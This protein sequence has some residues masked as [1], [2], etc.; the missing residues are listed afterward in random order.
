[1]FWTLHLASETLS[2]LKRVT[3]LG[4]NDARERMAEIEARKAMGRP[5]E[6]APGIPTDGW[7]P[8]SATEVPGAEGAVG[9]QGTP[10]RAA[11][12]NFHGHGRIGMSAGQGV[13]RR[14][15]WS[16]RAIPAPSVSL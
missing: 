1:M 12:L 3:G 11:A 7:S 10:F 13:P 14:L 6:S 5:W 2:R 9:N 16:E 8:D 15:G 4:L